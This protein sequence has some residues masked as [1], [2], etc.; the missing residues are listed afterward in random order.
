MVTLTAGEFDAQHGADE[1]LEKVEKLRDAAVV[2]RGAGQK[3]PQT[4]GLLDV[5][6]AGAV[7][8]GFRGVL[9]CLLFLTP[10]L[11]AAAGALLGCMREV[12]IDDDFL[13]EVG[14]NARA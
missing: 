1:A 14:N 10:L 2:G 11:G 5:T 3:K 6:G 12:G 8:G 7:G 9:L 13:R 4:R